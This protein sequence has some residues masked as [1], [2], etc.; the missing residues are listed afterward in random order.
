MD[1][2][3]KKFLLSI[4]EF[5]KLTNIHPKSLR[6]YDSIGV[7][8]PIWVDPESGYRYYSFYQRE[9]AYL[10]K[11]AL[12]CGMPLKDLLRYVSF[13]K[14]IINYD[15]FIPDAV[16]QMELQIQKLQNQVQDL[17]YL[18]QY[19]SHTHRL[20]TNPVPAL[21]QFPEYHVFRMPYEGVQFTD[22]W[23]A[24]T[25]ELSKL[26]GEYDI[27][28]FSTGLMQV[29]EDGAYH[30]Y[31][32]VSF[33]GSPESSNVEPDV[34]CPPAIQQH[35][36]YFRIPAGEYLCAAVPESG[37]EQ[38]WEWSAGLV[39][40]RPEIIIEHEMGTLDYH[41]F[42]PKLEQRILLRRDDT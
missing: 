32:Y 35:P 22:Q 17:K 14:K 1:K 34:Y 11:V 16:N 4:K 19:M 13:Q 2:L 18:Q 27:I 23:L 7:L 6:Y 8:K 24:S 28:S 3:D 37:L 10:V 31:L 12:D 39:P 40:E 20:S 26:L 30:S 9:E 42:P 38:A 29:L 25:Q 15:T 21:E 33:W 5:G 41:Y 36:Y